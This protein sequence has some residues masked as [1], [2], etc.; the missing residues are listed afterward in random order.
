MEIAVAIV[1]ALVGGLLGF[2]IQVF[3]SAMS[4]DAKAIDDHI[5]DIEK[6][7]K[8]AVDYWTVSHADDPGRDKILAMRLRGALYASGV[9]EEVA[10][11]ALGSR[12]QKYA[13]L[14]ARLDKTTTGGDFDSPRKQADPQ[15]VVSTMRCSG[16]IV[17]HLRTCR[18]FIYLWR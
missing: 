13:D 10:R 15:R 8:L 5:R 14:V 4:E 3:L 18:K 17:I 1:A 9:F 16:E 7:E 2:S 6:I 12:F 11:G